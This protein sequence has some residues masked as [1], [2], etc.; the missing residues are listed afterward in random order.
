[1]RV[2]SVASE[3]V[4]FV[5]TGGLADVVGALPAAL[6]DQGV[7]M[8]V[9]LPGYEAVIAAMGKHKTVAEE[10]NLFGGPAQLLYGKVDGLG[11]YVLHAPHLYDRT[12]GSPYLGPD[13]KDWPDNPQRFAALSWVAAFLARAGAGKFK[14][15]ILH[16]HDWQAGL[17]P[18]YLKQM[19]GGAA[20]VFTVHNIAFAGLAE[21]HH[22]GELRL[23]PAGFHPDGFEYWGQ[24]SALKAG[25]V[26]ADRVTTVSP[27][28]ARELRAPEFGMGMDGV[29]RTKGTA[30]RGILN[31]IDEV[32]WDPRSDELIPA[33]FDA[34]HSKVPGRTA[35]I[36][37][38]GLDPTAPGPLLVAV[39]RLT[40]QKGFDLLAAALPTLLSRGGQF[41]L[42]GSGTPEI[43]EQFLAMGAADRRVAVRTGYNEPLS[44]R[45]IAGGD[46][47]AVPSRF[48]PCGLTQLYGL[49]YGTLPLVA[50]TG[51][52]A[53]TV[54]EANHAARLVGAGTGFLFDA[55]DLDGLRAAVWR[56]CDLWEDRAAWL[57]VATAAMQHPVGW[58]ASAA[59]YAELYGELA[60][61][62]SAAA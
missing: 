25:L 1:M 41:A 40:E 17:A 53:D 6:E 10:D 19:G 52:L 60:G 9:L 5:K 51:G 14:P 16:C 20:T 33:P 8:R 46:A 28:Y 57:D 30:M 21:A 27:T 62:A 32:M 4:P 50:R 11:L 7:E 3:C 36:S 18:V 54:I 56:M 59:A 13:G 55:G 24:I 12:E 58:R 45:I 31:G 48:E 42:L 34:P 49:R 23:D 43:E 35:L 61:G 29:I 38:L 47:I 39:S 44:H 15:D 2:L 22:M 37:E 26:Y